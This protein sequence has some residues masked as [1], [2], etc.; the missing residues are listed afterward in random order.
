MAESTCKVSKCVFTTLSVL[1]TDACGGGYVVRQSH[2]RKGLSEDGSTAQLVLFSESQNGAA[3][4]VP[5]GGVRWD[6]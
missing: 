4:T 2:D 6:E 3:S 5:R 1:V